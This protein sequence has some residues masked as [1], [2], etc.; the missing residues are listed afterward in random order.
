M[1]KTL[2]LF[3]GV[4]SPR[5]AFR[6]LN[7]PIKA[8]DYVEIDE[9]CVRSYNSM[10]RNELSYKT[11][12]VVDYNLKPD[13]LIHGSPCF[14]GDTLVLTNKGYK[15]ISEI[16]VGDYVIDHTN[17]YNIVTNTIE[18]GKKEIW[19]I[20]AMSVNELNTTSNHKFYVREKYKEWNNER[21]V[22]ETVFKEP[23]WKECKDLNNNYYIGL[24]INQNEKIPQ[25]NGVECTRGK[26]TY[27]KNNL[28]LNDNTF[29]YIC[30]R[31]LGDGWTR[32]RKDRNNNISGAVICC[33]KH[34]D[35]D[36]ENKIKNIFNYTKVEDRTTYKYQFSNKELAMFLEQFG[37]GA[38]NKRIPGFVFDL[39]IDKLKSFLDGYF[40]SDGCF[41]DGIY[42]ATSIS[43]EL[44]YGV[45]QCIAKVY[46]RPF[47]ITK[48]IR[49]DTCEIEGRVVSQHDTYKITF[50][51]EKR[52]QDH[53]FYEM[54]YLWV[55]IHNIENTK[56][57]KETYDITVD[58]SHSF[59]ANGCIAHNCQS[60]SIAGKQEG[61]DEGS[62]TESSLMWETINII[63]NMGGWKPKYVVWEN[64]KNAINKYMK[65]NFEKY[66]IE[67]EKLGYTNS[68]DVLNA[69]DF[70][71]PQN[72]N[73][74]F[75]ISC[76]NGQAFDFNKLER[77]QMRNIKEFLET[78]V[79]D[80]Y[81][82]TQPSI[83]SAIGKKGIKRATV[84]E[85]YAYTITERQ[86]RCPAQVIHVKDDI[87]RFLT[88][89]EC[90]LLQGFTEEDYYNAARVNSKR[91]LYK[92]A[93]NAMPVDVM[94]AII[95]Q[96]LKI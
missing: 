23:E 81:I 43:R 9:K 2:E 39:P 76:L 35:K 44:I 89:K 73:R 20:K 65:H 91:A 45:G 90:W 32:K 30:G 27:I 60:F 12:T 71:L 33:G 49:S 59:T 38:I 36:F 34:E 64:V 21:R 10:F 83:L 84:I 77:K 3:G 79:S 1:I 88:D 57:Y 37:H 66:L 70:G 72:R 62:G 40:D 58:N 42:N 69:M 92:Q 85:D 8:I 41:K 75:T 56:E 82:V 52:K 14:T 28:N 96:L 48:S 6:E 26:K 93:G 16:K 50:A 31:F 13:L 7:V 94:M 19:K 68:F 63:K 15:N 17:R 24:S 80:E 51:I 4:G 61:A 5:V 47:S 54:G 29:W 53:A 86:D 78:E 74:V 25:W 95:K 67:L 11:Q 22:Y 18:Q 46:K 87:F 55:P